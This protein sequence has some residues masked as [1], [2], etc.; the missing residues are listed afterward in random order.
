MTDDERNL[1]L[2]VARWIVALEEGA[3]EDLGV[4]PTRADEIKLL[5]AK[6]SSTQ[7]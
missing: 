4:P 7:P 6:I 3:A 2:A 1:L 5:I